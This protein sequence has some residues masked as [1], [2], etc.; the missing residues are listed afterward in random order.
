MA[1]LTTRRI[2]GRMIVMLFTAQAAC[3]TGSGQ[4]V[5]EYEV[6]AAYLYNFVK[7]VEWPSGTLRGQGEPLAICTL[8]ENPFGDAL[9]AAVAGKTLDGRRIV[10]RQVTGAAQARGCQILFVSASSQ[11][12]FRTMAGELKASG[13]LAVGES[14]GFLADGGVINF[15]LDSG[16]VRLQISMESAEQQKLKISAK[17]LSLAELVKK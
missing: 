16:R 15:K 5:S 11:K 3:I 6:K 2:A 13:I 4:T 7:F 1:F 9:D 8:A 14:D 17:L 10:A 12:N